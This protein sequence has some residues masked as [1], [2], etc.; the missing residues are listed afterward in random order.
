MLHRRS[1]QLSAKIQ[2]IPTYSTF[3]AS[4][5]PPSQ[6]YASNQT[7]CSTTTSYSTHPLNLSL[8]FDC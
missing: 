4:S 3:N 8:H 1:N 2:V 6:P 7:I 5:T